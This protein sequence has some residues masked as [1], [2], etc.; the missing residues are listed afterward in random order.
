MGCGTYVHRYIYVH[1]PMK[2]S[3][4]GDAG[5]LLHDASREAAGDI[6]S[7]DRKGWGLLL[8]C[9]RPLSEDRGPGAF[10]FARSHRDLRFL[11]APPIWSG[12]V[13]APQPLPSLIFF[14]SIT[15]VNSGGSP[16]KIVCFLPTRFCTMRQGATIK[17]HAGGCVEAASKAGPG[18]GTTS[19]FV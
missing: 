17:A 10:F 7:A 3:S 19:P 18:E 4:S 15:V 8:Y 12:L 1:L 13:V 6:I 11:L 9:F 2:G 5:R 14:E 16:T